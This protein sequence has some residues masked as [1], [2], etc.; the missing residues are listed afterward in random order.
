[1]SRETWSGDLGPGAIQRTTP[2]NKMGGPGAQHPSLTREEE[3]H[4][5]PHTAGL[6]GG[7]SGQLY[8]MTLS[9]MN[10]ASGK[11]TIINQAGWVPPP[12]R[13]GGGGGEAAKR[14]KRREYDPSKT[15]T[16]KMAKVGRNSTC[17]EQLHK[18]GEPVTH[19]RRPTLQSCWFSAWKLI[20]S[21]RPSASAKQQRLAQRGPTTTTAPGRRVRKRRRVQVFALLHSHNCCMAH[22][23][24]GAEK[25]AQQLLDC[26]G[27]VAILQ[28]APPTVDVPATNLTRKERKRAQR[29]AEKEMLEQCAENAGSVPPPSEAGIPIAALQ[30][31]PTTLDLPA[32]PAARVCPVESVPAPQANKPVSASKADNP[33]GPTPPPQEKKSKESGRRYSHYH[34]LTRMERILKKLPSGKE[35]W[36]LQKFKEASDEEIKEKNYISKWPRF[37]LL[38]SLTNA[39][40]VQLTKKEQRRFYDAGKIKISE[41][42]R[43]TLEQK[44]FDENQKPKPPCHLRIVSHKKKTVVLLLPLMD[45]RLGWT[46]SIRGSPEDPPFDE[47][48]LPEH[49]TSNCKD[50]SEIKAAFNK[51]T[52]V[53]LNYHKGRGEEAEAHRI[54]ALRSRHYIPSG[55]G[56]VP[57]CNMRRSCYR[58]L[59]AFRNVR[60]SQCRRSENMN[61]QEMAAE[62]FY[63]A[64]HFGMWFQQGHHDGGVLPSRESLRTSTLTND[65]HRFLWEIAH[66]TT[67]ANAAFQAVDPK[68][69][70]NQFLKIEKLL[71]KSFCPSFGAFM[72]CAIN[73]NNNHGVHIDNDQRGTL[74][75]NIVSGNFQ[76][77]GHF[78]LVDFGLRL[79]LP[80]GSLILFDTSFR[81]MVTDFGPYQG[82]GGASKDKPSTADEKATE[83][84]HA[85]RK[86]SRSRHRSKRRKLDD[87]TP[88]FSPIPPL[89]QDEEDTDAS[90]QPPSLVQK[91][92]TTQNLEQH[93]NYDGHCLDYFLEDV[94]DNDDD[95]DNEI[96]VGDDS[97]AGYVNPPMPQF[98]YLQYFCAADTAERVEDKGTKDDE[99][100]SEDELPMQTAIELTEDYLQ[101]FEAEETI[102]YY[103][104]KAAEDDEDDSEDKLLLPKAI[105]VTEG[106]ASQLAQLVEDSFPAVKLEQPRYDLRP[107]RSLTEVPL[108]ET[109]KSL[110]RKRDSQPSTDVPLEAEIPPPPPT[111]VQVSNL[112][113]P[114]LEQPEAP[115]FCHPSVDRFTIVFFSNMGVVDSFLATGSLPKPLPKEKS[116]R[117]AKS[118]TKAK[119]LTKDASNL[120]KKK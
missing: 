29:K 19:G 80:S 81:H 99:D 57:L 16:C 53:L 103:K 9:G 106:A 18:L 44:F 85:K 108:M 65:V 41:E 115:K 56:R 82:R 97:S 27:P 64:L 73:L 50:C 6:L 104:V 76:S 116:P 98:D 86:R 2:R 89:Q 70:K 15:G 21:R 119:S 74:A 4:S 11:A 107:R 72:C 48:D 87:G 22:K 52:E 90:E 60:P 77:G 36:S 63:R 61:P 112:P 71:E 31:A 69:Y 75:A 113:E 68:K 54:A 43:K 26:G 20:G 34:V 17:K 101:F 30:T 58:L 5:L 32:P 1:M 35:M 83:E 110:K 94:P 42:M 33:A 117:K 46:N 45:Q 14:T 92:D 88:E 120:Q 10:G 7:P 23:R 39:A 109:S 40:A 49:N 24:I 105:E 100:Y 59:N 38:Q 62:A 67:L 3:H 55:F 111:A 13:D 78:C 51:A 84:T 118:Q 96:N 12:A 79:S 66:I 93:V 95:D 8:N 102:Q 114:T 47:H 37:C 28:P 25:K 91:A